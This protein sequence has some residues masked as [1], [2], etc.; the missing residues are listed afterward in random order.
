MLRLWERVEDFCLERGWYAD[1]HIRLDPSN[2][3]GR[4]GV[5]VEQ[6]GGYSYSAWGDTAQEA[7]ERIADT[8]TR[9]GFNG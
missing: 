6:P 8:L 4:V 7:I 2:N 9:D 1:L 3:F 5:R